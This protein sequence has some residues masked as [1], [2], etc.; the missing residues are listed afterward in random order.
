MLA[1]EKVCWSEGF[2]SISL[3]SE[4]LQKKSNAFQFG[5]TDS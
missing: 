5:I 1:G 2:W 3:L 4:I